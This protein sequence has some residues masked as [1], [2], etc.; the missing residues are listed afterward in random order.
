MRLFK[1]GNYVQATATPHVLSR[2]PPTSPRVFEFLYGVEIRLYRSKIILSPRRVRGLR[3]TNDRGGR[4]L[5]LAIPTATHA[6]TTTLYIAFSRLPTHTPTHTELEHGLCFL[7]VMP[8]CT[9]FFLT[10]SCG[11]FLEC[12]E[13]KKMFRKMF[14]S[15][16]TTALLRN[17]LRIQTNKIVQYF[18]YLVFK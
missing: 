4:G 5:Y 16:Q 12:T 11:R 2:N 7:L 10:A 18:Y 15:A 1:L 3:G 14:E 9:I 17:K 6:T 13:V 8:T